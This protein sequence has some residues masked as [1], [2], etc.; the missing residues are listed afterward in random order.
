MIHTS[1]YAQF[2]RHAFDF[3]KNSDIS[4]SQSQG[5]KRFRSSIKTI[6]QGTSTPQTSANKIFPRA[7]TPNRRS[8]KQMD[9]PTVSVVPSP[10]FTTKTH[11]KVSKKRQHRSKPHYH[12]HIDHIVLIQQQQK[13][14]SHCHCKKS[15]SQQ[16]LGVL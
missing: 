14:C 9:Q 1:S 13:P 3:I 5:Y 2:D 11:Q 15:K 16:I 7:S 4:M 10:R 12:I 8:I 6:H